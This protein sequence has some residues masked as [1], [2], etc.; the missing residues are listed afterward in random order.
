M[1]T[2]WIFI[3]TKDV[4]NVVSCPTHSSPNMNNYY[5][6]DYYYHYYYYYD[7]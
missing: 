1:E 7:K 3:T 6:N 5:N 2:E 4:R